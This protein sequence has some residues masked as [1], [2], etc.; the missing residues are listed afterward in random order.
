MHGLGLLTIRKA[1]SEWPP[2]W[3]S[4]GPRHLEEMTERLPPNNMLLVDLEVEFPKKAFA[5]ISRSL[6]NVKNDSPTV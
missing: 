5:R 2:V 4:I 6:K 1:M 3:K